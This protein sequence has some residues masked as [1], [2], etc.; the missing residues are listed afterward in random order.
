VN[1][2]FEFDCLFFQAFANRVFAFP[3]EIFYKLKYFQQQIIAT[4]INP[5]K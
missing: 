2:N 3:A 4:F 5:V 1:A